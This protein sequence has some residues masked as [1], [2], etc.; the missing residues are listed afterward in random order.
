MLEESVAAE[1][2]QN[3]TPKP[4][5]DSAAEPQ[6]MVGLPPTPDELSNHPQISASGKLLRKIDGLASSN[7]NTTTQGGEDSQL[8]IGLPPTAEELDNNPNISSD[9]RYVETQQHG[10]GSRFFGRR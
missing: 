7:S 5:V 3:G 8:P 2:A 9:G 6:I 4:T 10:S 1:A